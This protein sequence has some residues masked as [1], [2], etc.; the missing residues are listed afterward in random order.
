MKVP[1]ITIAQM[2]SVHKS[3]FESGQGFII[4]DENRGPPFI[5]PIFALQAP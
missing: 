1:G 3:I 2:F 4:L 5:P